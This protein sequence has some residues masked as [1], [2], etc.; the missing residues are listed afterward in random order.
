MTDDQIL[1]AV[2][3]LADAQGAGV[4]FRILRFETGASVPYR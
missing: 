1:D 2:A 3:A 4:P